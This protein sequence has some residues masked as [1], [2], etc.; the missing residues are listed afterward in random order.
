MHVG[1]T[2]SGKTHQALQAL[3][4]ARTGVYA[5]PLRLLAHEIWKRVNTGQIDGLARTCNL[6]TGEEQRWVGERASHLACTVEMTPC[7][8]ELDVVVLD[9]IQL[10]A[11]PDRGSSW[12]QVLLGANAQEVHV[13]GEDTA[14]GL[15]QRIAEECG[16][17]VEVRRYERLTP[18][19]MAKQSLNGDLTK[20]QPGDAIVA[21]NRNHIFQIAKQVTEK[22]GHATA[23]AYG[24]MP[25]EVRNQQARIFNDPGSSLNVLVASDAIGM[26]LNLK[27][28]RVIFH[29]MTKWNGTEVVEL[30][31]SQAKQIAGRAG[32]FGLHGAGEGGEV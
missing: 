10:L 23:L 24:A 11:D 32:R 22:T 19:K 30:S 13:C 3:V 29:R 14:V 26:G 1:P 16:D 31:P 21:F 12:M 20:I 7:G 17:V 4:R 15:V 8:T 25:P 6:L 28:K 27:I 18:L 5:G 9:E 2:N